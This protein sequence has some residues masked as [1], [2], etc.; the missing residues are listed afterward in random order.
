MLDEVFG[1][2]FGNFDI[3]IY[4]NKKYRMRKL[5]LTLEQDELY[6]YGCE[7]T[8]FRYTLNIGIWWYNIELE[9]VKHKCIKEE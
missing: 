1:R 3:A 4:T 6:C 9:Y 5:G 8:G 7:G 2:R